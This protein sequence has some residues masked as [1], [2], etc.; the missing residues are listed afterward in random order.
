M[1]RVK[2]TYFVVIWKTSYSC[3]W[4]MK[5]NRGVLFWIIKLLRR[6]CGC[7]YISG[8]TCLY[9]L[10]GVWDQPNKVYQRVLSMRKFLSNRYL[11]YVGN[12]F[13]P[14]GRLTIQIFFKNWASTWMNEFKVLQSAYIKLIFFFLIS[15]QMK[16]KFSLLKL[17]PR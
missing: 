16:Y 15:Q 12:K 11:R 17:R 2:I 5:I 9:K 1:V 3:S 14:C 4:K 8:N 13:I 6:H 10:P 7:K